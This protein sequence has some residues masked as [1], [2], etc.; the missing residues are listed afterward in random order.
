M[1]QAI[2]IVSRSAFH[3]VEISLYSRYP[4][5]AIKCNFLFLTGFQTLLLAFGHTPEL[6][7]K[8]FLTL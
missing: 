5:L 8:A 3:W 7:I 4:L 2:G 6:P 1:V